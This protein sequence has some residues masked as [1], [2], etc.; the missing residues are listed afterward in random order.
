M[1]YIL[2]AAEHLPPSV[3]KYFLNCLLSAK[4]V[5]YLRSY[6]QQSPAAG[7]QS[8]DVTQVKLY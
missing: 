6:R 2:L 1:D 5:R 4:Q 7:F 3:F 8:G